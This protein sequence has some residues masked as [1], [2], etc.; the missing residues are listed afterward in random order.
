[1]A[2]SYS[3]VDGGERAHETRHARA[4]IP[5]NDFAYVV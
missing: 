4:S 3:N 1:M 2:Y 5:H